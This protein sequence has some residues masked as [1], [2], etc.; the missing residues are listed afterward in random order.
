MCCLLYIILWHASGSYSSPPRLLNH[1]Q[2]IESSSHTHTLSP[3]YGCVLLRALSHL[4]V[5]PQI[6]SQPYIT[7]DLALQLKTG[8]KASVHKLEAAWETRESQ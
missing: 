4:G 8:R 3:K 1:N 5:P 6:P 7:M 2:Y